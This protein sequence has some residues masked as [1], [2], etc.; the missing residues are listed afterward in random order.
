MG[1]FA[2]EFGEGLDRFTAHFEFEVFADEAGIA[3]L[4]LPAGFEFGVLGFDCLNPGD[5]LGEVAVGADRLLHGA[6]D[7]II[8]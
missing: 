7:L 3:L 8:D 4:E 6:T 5:R 2:D 1:E